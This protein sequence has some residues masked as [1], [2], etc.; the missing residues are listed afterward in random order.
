MRR[1]TADST[2][3]KGDN[4]TVTVPSAVFVVVVVFV[5]IV[6]VGATVPAIAVLPIVRPL[7]PPLL[8]PSPAEA[9][10]GDG[11]FSSV[12]ALRERPALGA[13]RAAR[14]AQDGRLFRRR[15]RRSGG[16]RRAVGSSVQRRDDAPS[17]GIATEE[18]TPRRHFGRVAH[19]RVLRTRERLV[20]LASGRGVEGD[21]GDKRGVIRV[22]QRWR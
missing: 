16:R 5:V 1:A 4:V 12:R 11:G 15:S 7:P 6:V 17:V 3:L 22:A 19:F 9:S 18:A 14:R 10:S 21:G 20:P 8:S 13:F 2:N